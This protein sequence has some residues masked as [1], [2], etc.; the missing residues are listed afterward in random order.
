VGVALAAAA[1]GPVLWDAGCCSPRHEGRDCAHGHPA[2]G[3]GRIL[4]VHSRNGGVH[5]NRTCG[6]CGREV[7]RLTRHHLIPRSRHR[8]ILNSKKRRQRFSRED[9]N[10]TVPLCGPCHR[11]VHQTFTEAELEREYPTVQALSSHPEMA[12]FVDWISGKRQ[13]AARPPG[14]AAG[15]G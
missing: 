12:R 11:K 14:R 1:R 6:L 4:R 8:K 3:A 5:D 13:G 7:E 2:R 9:L 10:R 15:G